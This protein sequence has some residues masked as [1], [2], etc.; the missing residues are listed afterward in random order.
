MDPSQTYEYVTS[1]KKQASYKLKRMLMILA[2]VV[3]V[4]ALLIVGFTTRLF[5]PMMALVP[6]STWIIVWLTWRYVSV[7]YEYSMTGGIMTLNKIY[8]GRSRKKVADIR[9]KD[10]T[11]IAPFDGEYI[12]QAERYAPERTVDFTSD[13]QK[14]EVYIAL[15]ETEDKHRGILYFEVTD[16]AL[17][18][19]R[20]YNS[21]AVAVRR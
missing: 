7:E 5:V 1:P 21:Q 20:Y 10:M 9:I 3:Y 12:T 11:L 14:P 19:L 4:V 16:Q 8:G 15:Y 13:L 2:Y 6:L 18:I 17:R